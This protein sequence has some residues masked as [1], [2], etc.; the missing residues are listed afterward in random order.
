MVVALVVA[1][2]TFLPAP[3]AYSI[4]ESCPENGLVE[5]P[6][7]ITGQKLFIHS[8]FFVTEPIGDPIGGGGGNQPRL[9]ERVSGFS[10]VVENNGE[11]GPYAMF[12]Q[13]VSGTPPCLDPI[14]GVNIRVCLRPVS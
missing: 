9:Y 3:R 13:G 12:I 8:S 5:R 1:A 14:R 7:I 6:S 2:F 4:F 10:R 11:W